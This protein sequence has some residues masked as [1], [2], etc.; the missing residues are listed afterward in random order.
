MFSNIVARMLPFDFHCIQENIFENPVI[1]YPMASDT[2]Y[3]LVNQW[4][5]QLCYLADIFVA[6]NIGNLSLQEK[7]VTAID[8]K[9]AVTEFVKNLLL[10]KSC[11][12]NGVLVQFST[13]NFI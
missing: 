2:Q 11:V 1:G 3:G 6:F 10:W 12:V 4:I 5:A 8:A 7:N 9:E 13:L